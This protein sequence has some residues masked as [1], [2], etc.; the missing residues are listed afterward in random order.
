[1]KR[2]LLFFV[3]VFSFVS[4]EKE[5]Q[6]TGSAIGTTYN[7]TVLPGTDQDITQPIDSI[8]EAFNQSLST[9]HP[10]SL[11]SRL[12]KQVDSVKVG[13]LFTD[14]FTRSVE[15]SKISQGYFDPTVGPLVQA[16]GFG[17]DGSLV[18][19][20]LETIDSLKQFVGI[21]QVQLIP[22]NNDSSL[23]VKSN[24]QVQLDF[25]AIAK[26]TLVDHVSAY[27]T[28]QGFEN[29]LV[30]IGGE[31]VASGQNSSKDNPWRVGIDAPK[32]APGARQLISV[33]VLKNEAMAGSGNYRK[34]RKDPETGEEYVHTVNPITGR[35]GRSEILGVNVIASNCTDADAYATAFMA[36]PLEKAMELKSTIDGIE[37][38]IMYSGEGGMLKLDMT[39]GFRSRIISEAASQ[40]E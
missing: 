11:I 35:A 19:V 22:L 3:L 5:Q 2:I 31:I 32:Q 9:W 15:I 30:E 8:V 38:L 24:P 12:N 17:S 40:Q 29:Y 20:D 39:E 13:K 16:Y 14:V 6:F 1:M 33:V 28:R 25:S 34:F 4:C 37:V 26:G 18:D 10:N 23:V 7:I 27:L 21:E 36:M